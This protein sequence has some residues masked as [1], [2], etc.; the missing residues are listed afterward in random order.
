MNV[1]SKQLSSPFSTGGGGVHF[2]SEVQASFVVLMLSG[3]YAPCLPCGPIK[4]IKLQGKI[5]GYDTDDLI[6]F[7]EKS[8]TREQRKLLG[9]IK[10]SISVTISS[11]QLGEVIQAAWN[12]FNNHEKFTKGKDVIALITGPLSATDTRNVQWLLSQARHTK[13]VDEFLRNAQQSNFSPPKSSEKLAVMKHHLKS[14]NGGVD[15]SKDDLYSFLNHFHILSYDLGKEVGVVLPLLHSH[16][17]QFHQQN[18]NWIWSRIVSI[19]QSWNQDAGTIIPD[20]L[21]EDLIDIFKQ[22]AITEIPIELTT[23]QQISEKTDWNKHSHA[24]DLALVSLVGAWN[25]KN[26]SDIVVLTKLLGTNYDSWVP[27]ARE[28]LHRSDTPLLLK[29]GQWKIPKRVELLNSLG[30]WIFDQHLDTF[31]SLAVTVLTKLD[32]SFEFPAED[33]YAASIHG[34]ELAHSFTLRK[35]LAEGLAI[36]GNNTNVCSNC[37]QGKVEDTVVL[38]IREI[39]TNSD[40]IL[41]GSLNNLLPTLAEAAPEEFL[42]AVENALQLSPCPY[43]QLF[44]QEGKGVFGDNYLT[45]LLWALERLAWDEKYLVQVCVLLGELANHDP[46]GRWA[47]RPANSLTTILLPWFSQT[48]APFDKR[49]IAVETLIKEWPNIGWDL[50]IHLLPN[51]SQTS[52]GSNK[53]SWRKVIPDD[54]K[55]G[56]PQSEYWQ[57]VLYYANLA[58]SS[59]ENNVDRL[60]QLIDIFNNLPK[61]VIDRL[62]DIISSEKV[63][64]LPEEQRRLIWDHLIKLTTKHKRYADAKWALSEELLTKIETIADKLA[65]SNPFNLYQHLFSDRDF[66]LYEEKGN[67]KEQQL[68][69]DKLREE[70]IK[71]IFQQGGINTV[72]RFAESVKFPGQVGHALSSLN[73]PSIEQ[74]FLPDFLTSE[75]KTHLALVSSFILS[76]Y[77]I[78]GWVW[79][80][81]LDRGSWNNKQVGI[82]LSYLP[83]IKG[84]WE[85]LNQWLEKSQIEYWSHANVNPYQADEDLNYAID[86]LLEYERPNAAIFCL[87]K[88]LHDKEKIDVKQC[89]QALLAAL[90]SK[91]DTFTMD[92]YHIVELIKYLQA[93]ESVSEDDLFKVEWAYLRLLDQDRESK[94][95]LLESR[96]TNDPEF[97]CEVLSLVYKSKKQDE[98]QKELTE[99]LKGIATNAWHLLHNWKTPPGIQED[100]SFDSSKFLNWLQQ[101]KELSSESGHLE[102]ALITI[103]EVLIHSPANPDGLWIHR[104]IGEALNDRNSAE[105]RDGFRTGLFN[106]RGVH[107][108]DP[109]GKPEKELAEQY[110]QKA[111]DVENAGFQRL[112]ATLREL[113]DIYE[114]ESIRIQENYNQEDD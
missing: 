82:F 29:N 68:K 92:G 9:Q 83:F 6:V 85:R 24:T 71:E 27:K 44:L 51:Q 104:T 102:I 98:P 3:G 62:I 87:Y 80:D 93:D 86:K 91:E 33:R 25:E 10:Y 42:S 21:P 31:K 56:V 112:A 64:S 75:D 20:K 78:N 43:D 105:I 8:D 13:G 17:S 35:G 49:K 7:V 97:F 72:I 114:R 4:E 34:K 58:V 84:S 70:A 110:D 54:W 23:V 108:V 18:P 57:Q 1:K 109:T 5:D 63:L 28:I 90:S 61:P 37:S 111:E 12:D 47:N 59:A 48:L 41:W 77:Y 101:V 99:E 39:F 45:G 53:P 94:P 65:P 69:L 22:R 100:G 16:I 95:K 106:D 89:I 40:W 88:M 36:L 32:P 50:I 15:I 103:G 79:C 52:S 113:A 76:K 26:E 73:D 107:I 14:A 55:D 2:E 96:L 11:T 74:V 66:D 81:G 46:G 60:I 67:W 30:S 19:V 38:A